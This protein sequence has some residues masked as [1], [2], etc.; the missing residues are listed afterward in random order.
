MDKHH[1]VEHTVE[2]YSA[3]KWKE[4]LIHTTT[5]MKTCEVKKS[6]TKGFTVSDS[7]FIK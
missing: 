7:I 6:D 3:I 2:Y 5:W 4:V 1:V